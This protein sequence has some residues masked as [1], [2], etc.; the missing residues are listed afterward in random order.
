MFGYIEAPA[1]QIIQSLDGDQHYLIA[2]IQE[3]VQD[4]LLVERVV[5]LPSD[6]CKFCH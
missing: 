1:A 2:L 5:S 4:E 6:P 3:L